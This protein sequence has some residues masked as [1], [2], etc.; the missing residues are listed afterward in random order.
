M[1]L[2]WDFSLR[3]LRS[4]IIDKVLYIKDISLVFCQKMR[5]WYFFREKDIY[6]R[7][8]DDSLS[9][10]YFFLNIIPFVGRIILRSSPPFHHS[11]PSHNFFRNFFA[12]SFVVSNNMCTFAATYS[13]RFPLEQRAQGESFFLPCS[14]F[15]YLI[16]AEED[17]TDIDN[18]YSTI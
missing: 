9:P 7:V 5:L 2:R 3:F 8:F 14:V 4:L 16:N 1:I 12:K 11:S 17:R 13:P 10:P 15:S 18:L 6:V